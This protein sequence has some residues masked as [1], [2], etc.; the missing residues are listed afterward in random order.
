MAR[1]AADSLKY[2]VRF[3][4]DFRKDS[5]IEVGYILDG[6]ASR[7]LWAIIRQRRCA[8]CTTSAWVLNRVR[9]LLL[10]L[11]RG[12]VRGDGRLTGSVDPVVQWL[13]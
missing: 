2:L 10:L 13:R 9:H 12:V 6:R 5:Q 11:R 3:A 8:G 7:M 4:D 1:T